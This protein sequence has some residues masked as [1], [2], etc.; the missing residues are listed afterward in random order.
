M[1]IKERHE[2][3]NFALNCTLIYTN[4][5]N[6]NQELTWVGHVTQMEQQKDYWIVAASSQLYKNRGIFAHPYF[7]SRLKLEKWNCENYEISD[8][9]RHT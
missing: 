7:I 1:E 2:G 4:P 6:Q 5:T 3:E 9:I 8:T